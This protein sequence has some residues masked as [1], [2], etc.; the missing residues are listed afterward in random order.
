MRRAAWVGVVLLLLLHHD[1]WFWD[2]PA[3]VV[4]LWGLPAGFVY[5]VL[6]CLVCT[7]WMAVL[8]RVAGPSQPGADDPVS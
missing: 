1:V 7:V 8:W 2:A 3:P 5:H 4:A 6:F